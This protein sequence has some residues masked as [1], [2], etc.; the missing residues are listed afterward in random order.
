MGLFRRKIS[1]IDSPP[2][3]TELFS[4]LDKSTFTFL[5]VIND[6]VKK[7]NQLVE[8]SDMTSDE[9]DTAF[10]YVIDAALGNLSH[11]NREEFRVKL[12]QSVPAKYLNVNKTIA[13]KDYL[14]APIPAKFVSWIQGEL[15][16]LLPVGTYIS[17]EQYGMTFAYICSALKH[18]N[19]NAD[20]SQLSE[21][22]NNLATLLFVGTHKGL[23]EAF[24]IGNVRE[25]SN[26]HLSHI[27]MLSL[28]LGAKV[29]QDNTGKNAK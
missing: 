21:F 2:T 16:Q 22:E 11:T 10:Q 17:D 15:N 19:P 6:F 4:N 20:S 8:V 27:L 3:D 23:E 25:S 9:V 1:D 5:S 12:S 13:D 14:P 24:L 29:A 18:G 28:I 7:E 26:R